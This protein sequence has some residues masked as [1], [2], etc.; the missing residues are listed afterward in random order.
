MDFLYV[1]D[2]LFTAT[3]C[4]E[5]INKYKPK[6][7][8]NYFKEGDYF[9]YDFDFK[10]IDKEIT[11]LIHEYRKR[12]PV[13][14]L[15]LEPWR[16]GSARFKYYPGGHSFAHWHVDHGMQYSLR[17]IAV[18]IYLTKHKTGTEFFMPPTHITSEI[19]RAIMF[20]TSFTHAHRG[21]LCP[22]KKDRCILT[23]YAFL[24]AK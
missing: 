14:D 18:L 7:K 15:T 12:Y 8:K 5:L 19:G 20:P 24:H 16:F 11:T 9:F 6:T 4:K 23:T 10:I 1:K 22:D 13:V 3:K 17:I 2:K 21:H